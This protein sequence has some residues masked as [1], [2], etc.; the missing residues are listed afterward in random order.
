MKI[1]YLFQSVDI[2]VKKNYHKNKEKSKCKIDSVILLGVFQ[3]ENS[4]K[5]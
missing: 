2:E 1:S 4:S 5:F 3:N